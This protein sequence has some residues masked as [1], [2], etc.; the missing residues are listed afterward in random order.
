MDFTL[1]NSF[2]IIFNNNKKTADFELKKKTPFL[3]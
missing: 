3:E 1:N 2:G